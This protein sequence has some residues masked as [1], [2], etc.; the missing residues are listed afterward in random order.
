MCVKFDYFSMNGLSHSHGLQDVDDDVIFRVEKFAQNEMLTILQNLSQLNGA[1]FEDKDKT[2]FFGQFA[3]DPTQFRFMIGEILLI[4]RL[5]LH[6]R[7][8]LGDSTKS[9]HFQAPS[10]YTISCKDTVNLVAGT[11]F[12]QYQT[13]EKSPTQS[14]TTKSNPHDSSVGKF[15]T[16]L[17]SD[18][19]NSDK[20]SVHSEELEDSPT[21]NQI[22]IPNPTVSS[23]DNLKERLFEKIN[24]LV[25]SIAQPS[26]RP[27]SRE[28]IK[29][30]SVAGQKLAA[31]VTCVFC[32]TPKAFSVNT[33]TPPK[34]KSVYWTISN[35]KKHVVSQHKMAET[36][37]ETKNATKRKYSSKNAHNAP[38]KLKSSPESKDE[39]ENYAEN[40]NSSNTPP[41][42]VPNS[43]VDVETDVLHN[44]ITKQL[45][46]VSNSVTTNKTKTA[47]MKIQTSSASPLKFIQ[48]IK[49]PQDGNCLF[50]SVAHQLF[51]CAPSDIS[52]QSIAVRA[53]VVNHIR[54]N[55]GRFHHAIKGRIYEQQESIKTESKLTE[56]E[57]EE[58]SK[59]F[60]EE[61]LSKSGYYGGHESLI[62]V[63]EIYN[64]NILVFREKDTFSIVND[65]N[66]TYHRTICLAYRLAQNTKSKDKA[67]NLNYN[68]Y[69][70]VGGINTK[71]LSECVQIL[72]TKKATACDDSSEII[73][74]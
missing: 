42:V 9:K 27:F 65:F 58:K 46:A 52:E 71:V 55:F 49:I 19:E 53:E 13:K 23:V 70:S 74:E 32:E 25:Q 21:Q 43:I 67:N 38:K 47:N 6:V 69:D 40:L 62:A 12:G 57:M 5:V 34:S 41:E 51:Y 8:I 60:L 7:G 48:V 30:N 56:K 15:E 24:A 1:D 11:Y 18:T 20:H 73:N 39:V 22:T 35:L 61:S 3:F 64:V 28:T 29:I 33:F 44:Q 10:N 66:K 4:R 68:H 36:T 37:Q 31:E 2:H 17:Q 59:S 63:S 72:T 45:E 16:V 50:G 14:Q 26:M 54:V